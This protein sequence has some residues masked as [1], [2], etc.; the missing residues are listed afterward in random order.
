MFFQQ[1]SQRSGD[2][3]GRGLHDSGFVIFQ[4]NQNVDGKCFIG[5]LVA[6]DSIIMLHNLTHTLKAVTVL[7][8]VLLGCKQLVATGIQFMIKGSKNGPD[9]A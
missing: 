2:R 4:G 3:I 5:G 1:L 7:N 6:D 9:S 8:A